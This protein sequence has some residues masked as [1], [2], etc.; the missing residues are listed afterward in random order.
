M[1]IRAAILFGLAGVMCLVMITTPWAALA[2]R[3]RGLS[4]DLTSPRSIGE[5]VAV[6]DQR[7]QDNQDDI[8]EI[9]RTIR[10]LKLEERLTKIEDFVRESAVASD[11]IAKLLFALVGSLIAFFAT[12]GFNALFKRRVAD[13]SNRSTP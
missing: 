4:H 11:R 2:Q 10:N 3:N 1:P 6:H 9:R 8:R 12:Q 5:M 7:I 13:G